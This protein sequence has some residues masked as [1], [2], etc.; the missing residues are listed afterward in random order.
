MCI[1]L[2]LFLFSILDKIKSI[3]LQFVR[4]IGGKAV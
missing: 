4:F 1:F 2:D 3:D